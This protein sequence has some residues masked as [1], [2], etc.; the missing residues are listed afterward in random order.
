[1]G[2]TYRKIKTEKQ[3]ERNHKWKAFK[4]KR[5]IIKEMVDYENKEEMSKLPDEYLETDS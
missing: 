1:M 5:K 4:V 2:K 3:K